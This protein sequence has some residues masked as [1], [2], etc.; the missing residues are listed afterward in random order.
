MKLFEWR[1]C[2]TYFCVS[3]WCL[4][5]KST[6]CLMAFSLSHTHTHDFQMKTNNAI[7]SIIASFISFVRE[8]TNNISA[9]NDPDFRVILS[10]R[11]SHYTLFSINRKEFFELFRYI[12]LIDMYNIEYVIHEK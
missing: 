1:R 9:K 5:E 7:V 4:T 2:S 8:T 12:F 3:P 6:I 10:H 11:I